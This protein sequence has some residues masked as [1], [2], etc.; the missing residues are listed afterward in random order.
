MGF[1]SIPMKQVAL[2]RAL[3]SFMI[4]P[5]FQEPAAHHQPSKRVRLCVNSQVTVEE[6][7]RYGGSSG[8][9]EF[10]PTKDPI[11]GQCVTQAVAPGTA[12]IERE[13]RLRGMSTSSTDTLTD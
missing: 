3:L 13:I 11:E 5:Y 10:Q 8:G 2:H 9:G 12:F 4:Q 7:R 6:P 1:T